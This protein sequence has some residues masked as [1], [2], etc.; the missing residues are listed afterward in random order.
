M[1]SNIL[2]KLKNNEIVHKPNKIDAHLE[3]TRI[4][5]KKYTLL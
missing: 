1:F 4:N 2:T 5:R 3:I